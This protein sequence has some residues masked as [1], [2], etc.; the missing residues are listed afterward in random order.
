MDEEAVR[1]AGS[2]QR[3]GGERGREREREREREK[4]RER[5][6]VGWRLGNAEEGL[7]KRG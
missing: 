6:K 7:G 1:G 4:E 3:M 5:G 2:D